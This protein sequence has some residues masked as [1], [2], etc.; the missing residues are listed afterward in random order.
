MVRKQ[1]RLIAP[2]KRLLEHLENEETLLDAL[3]MI[4]ED[5][6]TLDNW[7]K[8]SQKFCDLFFPSIGYSEKQYIFL[9]MYPSKACNVSATCK[10]VLIG[11]RTFYNWCDTNPDFKQA[12]E[13][14]AE[15]QLDFAESMLHKKI[16]DGSTPE[17]IFYLKTKGKS[18]G[19]IETS[20]VLQTNHNIDS[21][22]NRTLEEL[23]T[24][25]EQLHEL[26]YGKADTTAEEI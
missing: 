8:S 23:R 2:M 19:Y 16:Q 1:G 20:E 18:R 10:S 26:V 6:A 17:L 22:T 5:S 4:N 25:R 11:R 24:Q 7:I 14:A 13:D 15:A 3:E 12:I 21:E 9:K